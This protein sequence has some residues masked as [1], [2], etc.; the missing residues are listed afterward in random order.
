MSLLKDFLRIDAD[1]RSAHE[2][3]KTEA[4]QRRGRIDELAAESKRKR[5]EISML[6]EG[7]RRLADDIG[8]VEQEILD[9][10]SRRD[11]H[12]GE[13]KTRKADALKARYAADRSELAQLA[14]DYRRL[15]SDFHAERERLLS[16]TDTGRMMDNY[17]QIET[18]LKDT[19]QPIPDAARKALQRE[20]AELVGKIGPLVAPPPSPE[21]IYRST[22][23]YSVVEGEEPRAFVA[24]GMADESSPSDATDLPAT[25]L[26]GAYASVV[27][28]FGEKAPRPSRRDGVV[29]FEMPAK[30]PAPEDTALDLFLAVED[31][32]KKAAAAAAVRTELTGVFVEPQI[33][34]AMFAR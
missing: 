25:L 4:F 6:E 27:E 31:G 3:L 30:N 29:V 24:L 9:L 17:F 15:R 12:D 21:G 32:L 20:R 8:R 1:R 7:L 13:A 33:A 5:D 23:T 26:Y 34:A 14:Q 19:G 28:K 18:F 10:E 11:S 16:Q 22:I 2:L